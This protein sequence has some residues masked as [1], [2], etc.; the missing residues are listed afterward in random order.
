MS[1]DNCINMGIYGYLATIYISIPVLAFSRDRAVGAYNALLAPSNNIQWYL[2]QDFF[3]CALRLTL[4]YA[5]YLY[6]KSNHSMKAPHLNI[7]R[8]SI[9]CLMAKAIQSQPVES[10]TVTEG[11]SAVLKPKALQDLG[12]FISQVIAKCIH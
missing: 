7:E 2:S 1:S 8:S 9:L 5:I 10:N 12:N 6:L 3:L 4:L 11:I